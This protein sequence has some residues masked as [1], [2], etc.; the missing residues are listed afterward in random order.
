M[1]AVLSPQRGEEAPE[2]AQDNKRTL[3]GHALEG[4]SIAGQVSWKLITCSAVALCTKDMLSVNGSCDVHLVHAFI[5]GNLHYPPI[6][7]LG[8]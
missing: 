7:E 6:I 4:V 8:L 3:A 2:Y 5:V 1:N